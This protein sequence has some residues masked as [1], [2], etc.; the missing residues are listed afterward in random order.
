MDEEATAVYADQISNGLEACRQILST[1][2]ELKNKKGRDLAYALVATWSDRILGGVGK[3]EP[4][5]VTLISGGKSPRDP[6][7]A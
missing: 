6:G 4:P 1:A 3:K 7:A 2:D 5:A